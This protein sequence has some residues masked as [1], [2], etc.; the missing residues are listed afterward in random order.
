LSVL[1]SLDPDQQ[2]AAQIIRGPLLIIAGPGS[3]KTCTLTH[4][5]ASMILEHAVPLQQCLTI[6]FTRKAA[7][8]MQERLPVLL[9]EVWQEVHVCSFHSFALSLL[10]EN[11]ELLGLNRGFRIAGDDERKSLLM[12]GKNLSERKAAQFLKHLSEFKRLGRTPEEGDSFKLLVSF[13][14]H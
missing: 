9:P 4:R 12:E 11:R 6:T 10:Q 7:E 8:E 1:S 13:Y 3:G 5:I 2:A 14:E